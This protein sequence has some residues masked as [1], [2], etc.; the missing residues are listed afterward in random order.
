MWLPA[1]PQRSTQMRLLSDI[2]NGICP[3]GSFILLTFPEIPRPSGCE[4]H[5]I[6][7]WEIGIDQMKSHQIAFLVINRNVDEIEI[8]NP[9]S[10]RAS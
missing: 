9:W 5:G 6:V 1:S 2:P 7:H 10:R 3:A 4:C 8:D